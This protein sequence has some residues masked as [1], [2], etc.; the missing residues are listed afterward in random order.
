MQERIEHEFG[1]DDSEVLI[2][3]S[4]G[5]YR[6][7]IMTGVVGLAMVGLGVAAWV[8][9]SYYSSVTAP[10]FVIMGLVAM[11]GGTLFLRP[12]TSLDWISRTRGRDVT[13]LITALEHLDRAHAVFRVLL[14]IFVLA[15]LASFV[16]TRTT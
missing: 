14:V 8:T 5:L 10:T 11:F 13:K 4:E 7:S 9:D 12:K 1:Y 6:F 16:L 15:R 2:S 3:L